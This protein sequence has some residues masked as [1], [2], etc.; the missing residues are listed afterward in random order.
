MGY[1]TLWLIGFG[2]LF[3]GYLMTAGFDYGVGVL[4]PFVTKG[5]QQRRLGLNAVGPFLLG[6]EV[7]LIVAL[8]MLI[9]T[10]PGFESR[11]LDGAYPQAVLAV[12]GAILT[13]V[14][15]LLRS[16][17][18]NPSLRRFFDTLIFLGGL[19]ASFGWGAVTTIFA[20]GVD[21]GA[22]GRVVDTSG[23]LGAFPVL[24]GLTMV[25]L[26]GSYGAAF[27]IGRTG[28]G[29]IAARAGRLGGIL[30]VSA[31]V[32]LVL[33]VLVG[34]L[35]NALTGSLGPA[36][37]DRGVAGACTAGDRV[38]AAV[39]APA[40]AMACVLGQRGGH[41]SAAA[42]GVRRQVPAADHLTFAGSAVDP[43]Q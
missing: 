27:L 9:G 10:L 23:A 12:L 35:G 16:R 20:A 19:F 40:P 3:T 14:S 29:P 4:L 36:C 13:I 5:D 25:A 38:G 34:L 2:V 43:G 7:W 33:T 21:L 37:G 39:V 31:A 41:R 17:S 6:N 26:M 30:G 22:D 11:L 32:L 18:P 1:A 15:V 42:F 8:G 24:G 28:D